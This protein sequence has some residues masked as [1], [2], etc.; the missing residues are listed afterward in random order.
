[1][2]R[3]LS[4]ISF[5]YGAA[6]LRRRIR[7]MARQAI[8]MA[9]GAVILLYALGF[10][11]VTLHIWLSSLWGSLVSAGVIGAVLFV[12]GLIVLLLALRPHREQARSVEQPLSQ[13]SATAHDT[14]DRV[15]RSLRQSGSPL[16]NPV[17]QAAGIAL[18]IGVLLGR[19]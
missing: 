3:L 14:Y 4:S 18:I 12:I 6:N 7:V 11:L 2:L 19:R 9:I 8:L 13:M 15:Q 5:A 1:M 17:V 10:G 16:A